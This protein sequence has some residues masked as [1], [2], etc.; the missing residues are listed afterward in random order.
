[1][2]KKFLSVISILVAMLMCFA[3]VTC[4]KQEPTPDPDPDQKPGETPTD[5]NVLPADKTI[6]A[7]ESLLSTYGYT[8]A[9]KVTLS[10]DLAEEDDVTEFKLEK[11]GDFI[12]IFASDEDGSDSYTNLATGYTYY[13]VEDGKY[14][15]DQFLPAGY[16]NYLK[17]AVKTLLPTSSTDKE[18]VAKA[19]QDAIK[20]DSET[21][22]GT[23]TLS[24]KDV[25]NAVLTPVQ[26]AYAD[27][28]GVSVK[29]LVDTY[30][31]LVTSD[32][33]YKT[34]DALLDTLIEK[35]DDV[36]DVTI[37]DI[38]GKLD[39]KLG[40]SV[41]DLVSKFAPLAPEDWEQIEDATVGYVCVALLDFIET[42]LPATQDET[43]GGED[44]QGGSEGGM[45]EMIVGTVM[46]AFQYMM[47]RTDIT[48]EELAAVPERLDAY[49]DVIVEKLD[50][51]TVKQLVDNFSATLPADILLVIK[52]GVQVTNL[53]CEVKFTF[54]DNY[55]LSKVTLDALFAHD[56]E[57]EENDGASF[58]ANNNYGFK[59][60]VSF[61]DYASTG[62]GYNLEV[63]AREYNPGTVTYAVVA[64]RGTVSTVTFYL[65]EAAGATVD[66][67]NI[68]FSYKGEE[69]EVAD[70]TVTYD[71]ATKT[72]SI[73]AAPFASVITAEDFYTE[74][75]GC[76][77]MYAEVTYAEGQ[78]YTLE[79][80]IFVA[81]SVSIKS[82]IGV[83]VPM[84]MELFGGSHEDNVYPDYQD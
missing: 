33:N 3:L 70:G 72:F 24:L 36:K 4:N 58:L 7:I 80:K 39:E 45:M 48:D 75:N 23:Y 20:Y 11:K 71:A 44:N 82:A 74:G 55:K 57:A 18:K 77:T 12:K 76:V 10:S 37:G 81:E 6:A 21:K 49:K 73:Q 1:M 40:L 63:A 30:L 13:E 53:D 26:E 2:N 35:Y 68:E 27:E 25:A 34:V 22:T 56:Y 59:L 42:K 17:E 84:F 5:T 67:E 50:G 16:A 66:V 52:E 62:T 9:G 41:K 64:A 8:V 32:E 83:S 65:E 28:E 19:L 69:L 31:G 29:E 78:S 43:A 54:D 51:V 38:I 79:L 46:E 47:G 60:D 15:F 61:S 14:A